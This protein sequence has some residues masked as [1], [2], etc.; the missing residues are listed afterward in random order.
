MQNGGFYLDAAHTRIL[1]PVS[2]MNSAFSPR[3]FA[4]LRTGFP[5]SASVRH[6]TLPLDE[7]LKIK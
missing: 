5:K 4:R 7:V 2:A 3:L 6:V 1:L